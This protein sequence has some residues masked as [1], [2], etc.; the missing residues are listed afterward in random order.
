MLV[1]EHPDREFN[2]KDL[3][4]KIGVIQRYSGM[5]EQKAFE[6]DNFSVKKSLKSSRY[7]QI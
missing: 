4:K 6:E 2:L 1:I 3:N 5:K 7:N